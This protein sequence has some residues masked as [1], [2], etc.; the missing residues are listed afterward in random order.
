[1]FVS[2]KKAIFW[3][4]TNTIKKYSDEYEFSTYHYI[5]QIINIDSNLVKK[6][7]IK[8]KHMKKMIFYI[9]IK[10]SLKN[11]NSKIV[12]SKKLLTPLKSFS[13][14]LIIK[15]VVIN[16]LL[17]FLKNGSNGYSIYRLKKC[18]NITQS[19]Y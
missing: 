7:K 6:I 19:F 18:E 16:K 11:K 1:M 17:L 9:Y 13:A 3:K 2:I 4:K 5:I 8:Y 14:K 12:Y 15:V 10:I